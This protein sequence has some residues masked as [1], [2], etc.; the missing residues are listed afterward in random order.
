VKIF[1]GFLA[2]LNM[3]VALLLWALGSNGW[4][5]A[6]CAVGMIALGAMEKK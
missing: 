4:F 1:F 2:G 6:L 5:N 3:S